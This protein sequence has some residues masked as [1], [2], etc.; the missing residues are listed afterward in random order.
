MA[1]VEYEGTTTIIEWGDTDYEGELFQ[2]VMIQH[3]TGL[4]GIVDS[5]GAEILVAP[6]EIDSLI[7]ALQEAKNQLSEVVS[8]AL[9]EG[10]Q[11]ITRHGKPAVVVVAYDQFQRETHQEKLSTILR[12]CPVRG[13]NTSSREEDG[14]PCSVTL[15]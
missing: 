10:P 9:R 6:E 14:P 1:N 13:W 12:E 11:T 5:Y 15:G 2:A 8:R 4:L 3:I 7:E